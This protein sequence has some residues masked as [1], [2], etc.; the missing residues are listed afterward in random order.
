VRSFQI[1]DLWTAGELDPSGKGI[2]G[3]HDATPEWFAGGSLAFSQNDRNLIY[4]TQWNDQLKISLVDGVV[5][6][7]RLDH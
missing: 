7:E 2:F 5:S 6:R 1:T 3:C 4:R